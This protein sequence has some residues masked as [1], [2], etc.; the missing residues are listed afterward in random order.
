MVNRLHLLTTVSLLLLSSVANAQPENGARPTLAIAPDAQNVQP[1]RIDRIVPERFAQPEAPVHV[2][3]QVNI[4]LEV[5][6]P[7]GRPLAVR[8]LGAPAGA[9]FS[10]PVRTLTWTP[11]PTQRGTHSIRFVVWNGAREASQT[12]SLQVGANRPP[13]FGNTRY[14]M[15]AGSVGQATF[16]ATDP[17]GDPIVYSS[18]DLPAGARLDSETG[19]LTWQPS[20]DEVGEH[21]MNLTVS[22]G[23]TPV[24]ERVFVD[25]QVAYDHDDDD[26]NPE[27]WE[28]YLL[29]GLGYS[30]YAPHERD[31]WGRLHGVPVE[32]IGGAWIHRNT[33]R[34]PSH[35]RIYLN[36]ELLRSTEQGVP[37]LFT[38]ALGFS[39]SLERN[40]HRKWLIP[41]YG[42]DAGGMLHRDMG[43][44]FQAT[45][46]LGMHF[47]SDPNIFLS[48]RVGYRLVPTDLETLGGWHASVGGDFSIC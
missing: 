43:S 25:V 16:S 47:Y 34:G 1:P 7:A 4:R 14:S 27:E 31:R 24:T 6:D 12:I 13:V 3:Q 42:L 36:T 38:Y 10:E 39:L 18:T 19:V 29:P 41:V 21:S 30:L 45:P 48:G 11:G 37:I 44:H 9:T 32:V 23:T 40:P 22:D 33:N 8:A 17:E 20:E 2:G 46:Y 5:S 35:G 28:S 15:Q 26:D